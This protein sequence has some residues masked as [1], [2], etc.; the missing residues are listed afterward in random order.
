M[1]NIRLR[2]E[3]FFLFLFFLFGSILRFIW[4]DKYPV[5][6]TPDEAA[7]GYTA[8]SI[9]KTGRDEW[10]KRFPLNPRSFGDF[11]P[12]LQTYLMIPSVAVFG[13]NEFAVRFPNALLSS[14][15]IIGVFLLAKEL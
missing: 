5:G 4:L 14:L 11:K 1:T 9:L 6:F 7:Q 10:G 15:A 8:Y 12:P 2:K 13:L 3:T